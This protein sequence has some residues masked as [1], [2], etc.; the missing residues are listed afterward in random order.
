MGWIRKI[1]EPSRS[2]LTRR[3]PFQDA[4]SGHLHY[5]KSSAFIRYLL[6]GRDYEQ[7][8]GFRAYLAA[9]ASGGPATSEA[10]L[11]YLGK[12]WMELEAEFSLWV[13]GRGKAGAEE[14]G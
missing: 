3:E 1:L 13:T 2:N 7:A 11:S 9:V 6:S 5:A 4:A 8:A 12:G 10:L 14:T